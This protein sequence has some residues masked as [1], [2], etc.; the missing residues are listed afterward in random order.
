M[1]TDDIAI[2]VTVTV[3]IMGLYIFG[4][5]AVFTVW[6]EDWDLTSSVYFTWV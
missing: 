1:P 4:G 5:A 3:I 6:E 2:P